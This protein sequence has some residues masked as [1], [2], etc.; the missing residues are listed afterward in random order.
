MLLTAKNSLVFIKNASSLVSLYMC[1]SG[2]LGKGYKRVAAPGSV[3]DYDPVQRMEQMS[4]KEKVC[5][6]LTDVQVV[7]CVTRY[8]RCI[9]CLRLWFVLC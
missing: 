4:V 8:F 1:E 2:F 3:L 5:F 9:S 6:S 7:K